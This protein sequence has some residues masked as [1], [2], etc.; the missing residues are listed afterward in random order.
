MQR[1]QFAEQVGAD[2]RNP[3]LDPVRVDIALSH[4]QR[5]RRDVDGVDF[6]FRE[7]VGTGN[8]N[9]AAAGTHVENM[10]RLI[11]QNAGEAVGDQFTDR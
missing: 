10:L 2:W 11:V 3:V 5:I 6:G 4:G 7:R 1:R 8:R 9:T